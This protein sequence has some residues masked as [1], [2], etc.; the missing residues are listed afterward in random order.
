VDTPGLLSG[1]YGLRATGAA[2]LCPPICSSI[3][4]KSAAGAIGHQARQYVS[5]YGQLQAAPIIWI[6][7]AYSDVES[8]MARDNAAALMEYQLAEV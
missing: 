5:M 3:S 2:R 6:A 8:C 1:R 7:A 4:T